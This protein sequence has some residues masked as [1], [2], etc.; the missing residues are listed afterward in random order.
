MTLDDLR[1]YGADVDEGL[2]RCMGNEAIYLQLVGTVQA[3]PGFAELAL[4][5][6]SGD[7]DEAFAKAHAL[8]GVAGNLALT[9]LFEPLYEMTE[10]LRAR[11]QMDYTE[12]LGTVQRQHAALRAL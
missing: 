5:L 11:T 4:A 7:L 2:G 10:L 9:P 12:L 1:A 6:E 3:E 8:K